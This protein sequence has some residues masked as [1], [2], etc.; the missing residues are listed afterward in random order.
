MRDADQGWDAGCEQLQGAGSSRAIIN[1]QM[2]SDVG[3]S[4]LNA[5]FFKCILR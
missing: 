2:P 4:L 1:L 3:K 5:L